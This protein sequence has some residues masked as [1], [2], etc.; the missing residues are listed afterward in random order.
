MATAV[1]VGD[2][3]VLRQAISQ[4]PILFYGG[5]ASNYGPWMLC[6]A[7]LLHP[8]YTSLAD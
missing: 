7:M 1:Q 3:G 4:T 6:F 2:Y 8:D 5:K